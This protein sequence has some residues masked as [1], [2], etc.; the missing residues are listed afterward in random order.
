MQDPL[1]T[2]STAAP[3]LR[4][5]ENALCNLNR[6]LA[7]QK[8]WA[9]KGVWS[10]KR[11]ALTKELTKARSDALGW[12]RSMQAYEAKLHG[13][14]GPQ[15]H[16]LPVADQVALSRS[17]AQWVVRVAACKSKLLALAGNVSNSVKQAEHR[18]LHGPKSHPACEVLMNPNTANLSAEE[19]HHTYM[20]FDMPKHLIFTRFQPVSL[21]NA[22]HLVQKMF[23]RL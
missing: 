22:K 23:V 21:W 16:G 1:P 6:Q 2:A 19:I 14:W 7:M 10:P 3:V 17:Y 9:A 11:T 8:L 18:A 5:A 13:A 15:L 12:Q 4:L 20:S